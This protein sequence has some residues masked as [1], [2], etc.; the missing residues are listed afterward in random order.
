M[1]YYAYIHVW[2]CMRPLWSQETGVGEWWEP[3][4]FPWVHYVPISSSLHNLSLGVK[5][6]RAHQEQSRA[7]AHA[8]HALISRV[9]SPQV[10]MYVCMHVC[11]HACMHV[12]MHA[13]MYMYAD[14]PRPLTSGA[15]RLLQR[16]RE[17]IREPLPK[18]ATCASDRATC[19]LTSPRQVLMLARRRSSAARAAA[20][21][22]SARGRL[23]S[24][25][26][27][28]GVSTHMRIL[29]SSDTSSKQ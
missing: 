18:E 12:C 11:T 27:A 19:P 17:R 13:C 4:L 25:A 20:Q 16:P 22:A 8:A 1:H 7:I 10:C 5:W 26:Y 6:V 9:L 23:S 2:I 14:E 21:C 3:L 15:A 24:S 29:A 28:S